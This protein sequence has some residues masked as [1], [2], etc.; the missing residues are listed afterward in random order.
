MRFVAI[1]V[2]ILLITGC[3]IIGCGMSNYSNDVAGNDRAVYIISDHL[4]PVSEHHEIKPLDK[5]QIKKMA[6]ELIP[7]NA[8]SQDREGEVLRVFLSSKDKKIM[9]DF[10]E[11]LN[12]ALPK[13]WNISWS[14]SNADAIITGALFSHDDV[15]AL[16]SHD[17]V[18]PALFLFWTVET[19]L[20]VK[21][22]LS[23]TDNYENPNIKAAIS[24]LVIQAKDRLKVEESWEIAL[25]NKSDDSNY[26]RFNDLSQIFDENELVTTAV[27]SELVTVQIGGETELIFLDKNDTSEYDDTLRKALWPDIDQKNLPTKFA[28]EFHKSTGANAILIIE[29]LPEGHFDLQLLRLPSLDLLGIGKSNN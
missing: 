16:F 3:G 21:R 10:Q 26:S 8:N 28:K 12:K 6:N 2:I 5:Q 27:L 15:S 18:T 1:A 24:D 14:A 29:L 22:V 20:K 13:R 7:P 19:D 25:I 17:D 4:L 23:A 9:K 11:Y